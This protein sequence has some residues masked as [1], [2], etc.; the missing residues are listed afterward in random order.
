M[1]AAAADIAM[2]R[3]FTATG[4]EVLHFLQTD[5]QKGLSAEEAAAAQAKY[6][7]NGKTGSTEERSLGLVH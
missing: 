1:V 4:E 5:Q 6:G 2:E 3:A 7:K